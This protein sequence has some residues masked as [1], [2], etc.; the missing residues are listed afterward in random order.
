MKTARDI[1][2]TPAETLAPTATLTEAAQQLRD[3][4]V[5]SLPILDGDHLVGVVTDRDIVVRGI[6]EGL[7]PSSAT[8]SEVATGAVVTVDV[9]DDAEKVARIMGERQVRRVPVLDGGKLVGVIAQADVARDLDAR[10]TGDVV[11][12]ISQR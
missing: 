5:G 9:A 1:M 7:D 2:T 11:E 10:T 6:A 3:L 4:N 8:V 12:D